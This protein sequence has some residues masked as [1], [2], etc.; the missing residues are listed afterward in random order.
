MFQN[1]SQPFFKIS[2]CRL[3]KYFFAHVI[4]DSPPL[5]SVNLGTSE[6]IFTFNLKNNENT[7]S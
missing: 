1:Q 5:Q 4:T 6:N 7:K 3:G 2:S